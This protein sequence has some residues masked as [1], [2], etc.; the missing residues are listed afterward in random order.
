MNLT[1]NGRTALVTGANGGLGAH[2]APVIRE[3]I[4]RSGAP[5]HIGWMVAVKDRLNAL[6]NPHAHLRLPDITIDKVKESPM[7]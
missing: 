1:L 4:R 3:Y 7:L 5:E 2:F 6:H